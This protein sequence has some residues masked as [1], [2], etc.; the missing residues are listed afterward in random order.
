MKKLLVINDKEYD[1]T[2]VNDT[3]LRVYN[4]LFT[5]WYNDKS[6]SLTQNVLASFTAVEAEIN[7]QAKSSELL[8]ASDFIDDKYD[9]K[10]LNLQIVLFNEQE[11]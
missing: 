5:E 10:P 2:G 7:M 6:L 1:V 9:E 8:S 11:V 4:Y 3:I